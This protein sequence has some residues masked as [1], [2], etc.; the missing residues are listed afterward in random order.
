[1]AAIPET[2]LEDRRNVGTSVGSTGS[3]QEPCVCWG[4]GEGSAMLGS[5]QVRR[6]AFGST[7]GRSRETPMKGSVSR[8]GN[9]T[10]RPGLLM[11]N[12]LM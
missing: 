6:W 12:D 5:E 8:K 1:M 7:Q 11:F 2:G 4:S 9:W 3:T 10:R